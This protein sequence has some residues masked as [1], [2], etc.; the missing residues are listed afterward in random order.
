MKTLSGSAYF[1]KS[2]WF[3]NE[4]GY[5]KTTCS[6]V[7]ECPK[8]AWVDI[9]LVSFKLYVTALKNLFTCLLVA[10]RNPFVPA[11]AAFQFFKPIGFE[12]EISSRFR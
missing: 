7:N 6:H 2:C 10:F 8:A 4:R 1:V 5:A 9:I 3:Y 11:L 12:L